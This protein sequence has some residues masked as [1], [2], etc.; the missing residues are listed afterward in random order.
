MQLNKEINIKN[1]GVKLSQVK[2]N[3]DALDNLITQQVNVTSNYNHIRVYK[4]GNVVS[5]D[6]DGT[7][8]ESSGIIATNL[9]K[10]LYDWTYLKGMFGNDYLRVDSSGKLYMNNHTAGEWANIHGVY[11]CI[12]D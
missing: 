7:I 10:A 1:A 2:K 4:Y 12:N 8:Q 5:I 9:P 11:I 6:I 3:K